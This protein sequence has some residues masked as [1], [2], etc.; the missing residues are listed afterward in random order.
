MITEIHFPRMLR[1]SDETAIVNAMYSARS[2][3]TDCR[4]GMAELGNRQLVEQFDRQI[5][6]LNEI[7]TRIETAADARSADDSDYGHEPNSDRERFD[8]R[9]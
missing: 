2:V 4:K 3:F 5:A 6:E 1:E 8:C 9:R 7:L